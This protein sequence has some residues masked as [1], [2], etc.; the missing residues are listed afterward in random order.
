MQHAVIM[1]HHVISS[2]SPSHTHT[3]IFTHIH[4]SGYRTRFAIEIPTGV[5][6]YERL[7]PPSKL[8]LSSLLVVCCLVYPQCVSR[9][10]RRGRGAA[11]DGRHPSCLLPIRFHQEKGLQCER[12][13]VESMLSGALCRL[14]CPSLALCDQCVKMQERAQ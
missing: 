2:I 13:P 10:E 4:I 5:T 9:R 1:S 3:H 8:W 14:H 12:R 6:Q 11:R 7:M